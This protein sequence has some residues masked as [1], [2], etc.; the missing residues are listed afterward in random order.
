MEFKRGIEPLEKMNVGHTHNTIKVLQV[1]FKQQSGSFF[2]PS[3]DLALERLHKICNTK[4]I[5]PIY[6]VDLYFYVESKVGQEISLSTLQGKRILF[7]G[8][9]FK[10][11]H[12]WEE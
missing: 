1:W 7:A 9:I 10:I 2:T 4:E 3:T 12:I 6:E 5:I 8:R 11:P